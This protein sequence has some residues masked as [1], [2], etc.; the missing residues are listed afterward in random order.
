MHHL[1]AAARDSG[2]R[3][4][5]GTVLSNNHDMRKLM[6]H[7]GFAASPVSDDPTVSEFALELA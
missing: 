2:Y 4:M 5:T 3:R 1:I 6:A 7:L